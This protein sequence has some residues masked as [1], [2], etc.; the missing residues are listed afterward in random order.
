MFDRVEDMEEG[1]TYMTLLRDTFWMGVRES[2]WMVGR[3]EGHGMFRSVTVVA[4]LDVFRVIQRG[5]SMYIKENMIYYR[6]VSRKPQEAME[7]RAHDKILQSILGDD[8]F[9]WYNG[10]L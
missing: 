7:R 3:F 2:F 5:D 8:C 9:S 6:W 4:F 10:S 1:C